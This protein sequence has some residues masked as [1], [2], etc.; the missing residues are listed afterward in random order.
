M[1]KF[2]FYS[3]LMGGV[4]LTA[5]AVL[6]PSLDCSISSAQAQPAVRISAEVDFR[7]A[8]APHGRWVTH[9]RWGDVWIPRRTERDWR[10]YTSGRWV[11]TE[12]WGWYWAAA[13]EWGW[14]PYHYGRW[15]RDREYGW[16]WIPGREWGPAW[17]TW[18]RGAQH[19]GWSPLPPDEL[20]EQEESDPEVW[21]FVRTRDLVAPNVV[22]VFV[23]YRETNIYVRETV[24]VNRTI[25]VQGSGARIAANPGVPPSYI[26]VAIGRPLQPFQVQPR[27]LNG[28]VGVTGAVI[29]RGGERTAKRESIV[30][31]RNVIQPAATVS[32]PVAL[33]AGETAA[34]T[35]DA[36]KVMQ[37]GAQTPATG[38]PPSP[39]QPAP[40]TPG[41]APTGTQPPA[42]TTAPTAPN[43][44]PAPSGA[45]APP[46][47][48]GDQATPKAMDQ[49]SPQFG[50]PTGQQPASPGSSQPA[51]KAITPPPAAPG[52]TQPAA[53]AITPPPAAPSGQQK[54]PSDMQPPPKTTAP[55]TP[56]REAPVQQRQ[57]PS[58]AQPKAVVP[59]GPQQREAPPVQRQQ[60][61]SGAKSDGARQEAPKQEAPKA[62]A[63]PVAPSNAVRPDTTKSEPPKKEERKSGSGSPETPK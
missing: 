24:V 40:A 34:P 36:P 53:K 62:E 7:E 17:V 6:S 10:P 22:R 23:P 21:T 63:R 42:K 29:V 2:R 38:T 26:A 47:P 32:A 37:R 8:L 46:A 11:Y 12:E 52:G 13:E 43:S 44:A 49:K 14:I 51:A 59:T 48:K 45:G 30:P 57:A 9:Q 58:D 4:A 60:I 1:Q 20:I 56:Q 15:A 31:Q 55:S 39:T 54:A 27:V 25:I 33:R 28:T 41:A 35:P 19:V 61:P 50:A 18:R 16:V 5:L 3:H